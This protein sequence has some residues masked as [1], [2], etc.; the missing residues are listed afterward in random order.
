M[1]KSTKLSRAESVVAHQWPGLSR[2]RPLSSFNQRDLL[3]GAKVEAEHVGNYMPLAKRMAADH[4]TEDP[5]YYRKAKRAG[6]S[7]GAVATAKITVAD[8]HGLIG[9]GL[10]EH[11]DSFRLRDLEPLVLAGG[12][13]SPYE[14]T[15]QA[16][17]DALLSSGHARVVRRRG[18]EVVEVLGTGGKLLADNI[19]SMGI[20]VLG[21]HHD[22][23]GFAAH[24]KSYT[25][26]V[27]LPKEALE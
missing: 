7:S 5:N 3:V 10:A 13:G 21:E 20:R 12:L 17:V 16:I 24:N 4:L 25:L 18:E 19:S 2:H 23:G 8:L 22:R 14:E 9:L 11:G 26:L 27:T 15:E 1:R 6:L